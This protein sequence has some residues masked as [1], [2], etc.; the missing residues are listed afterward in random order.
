MGLVKGMKGYIVMSNSWGG[1][2]LSGTPIG[3]FFTKKEAEEY[4]KA[5]FTYSHAYDCYLGVGIE[6]CD[7]YPAGKK[8]NEVTIEEESSDSDK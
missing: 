4:I 1:I 5:N 7:F 8:V 3:F 6:E 2:H